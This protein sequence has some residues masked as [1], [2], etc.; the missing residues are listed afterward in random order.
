[1]NDDEFFR[2]VGKTE[3]A[4]IL[5]LGTKRSVPDRPTHH[6]HLWHPSARVVLSD[7]QAGIDVDVIADIHALSKVFPA[8]RFD[9]VVCCSVFEHVQRPWIAAHE[10]ARVTKPGGLIFVQTHQSFPLHGYP[11]DYWRFTTDSLRTLFGDCGLETVETCYRFPA[12]VVSEQD[13]GGKD[14]PAFLN[15]NILA[16]KPIGWL[17]FPGYNEWR[18][19]HPRSGTAPRRFLRKLLSGAR[20]RPL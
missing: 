1:M 11:N 16:R 18:D 8:D 6:K 15:V 20:S 17:D 7:F 2:I 10:M 14:C 3:N 4:D 9:F 12:Q 19:A 13:P 5:E